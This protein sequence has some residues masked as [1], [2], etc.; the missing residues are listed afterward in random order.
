MLIQSE[1][2]ALLNEILNQT[3]RLRK[4][5][6]QAVY[7]CP[8]CKHYKRKLEINLDT[9]QWHCWT[10]NIKGSFLGSFLG[11]V[12]ANQAYRDQMAK[13]TGDL[14][15]AQR[16]KPVSAFN[17]VVLPDEFHPLSKP[18]S[19]VEYKNALYY[20]KR[21]GL[22]MEDIIRHNIGYCESGTYEYHIIV[23]SY[24]ADCKLNFF[25]GRRYYDTEGTIAYKKPECSMN[26]VGFESFVNY[27]EEI[28]LCEGVFDAIAIRNNAV[29][30]FGKYPSKL[31]R[32]RMILNNVKRANIILDDDAVKDAIRNYELLTKDVPGLEVS[33][34][35]LNGK[36]P[37]DIGFQLTHEFIR[38]AIP[39]GE[40]DLLK[41]ELYG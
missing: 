37:S 8:E 7:F 38:N 2:V 39:F 26:I 35:R 15:I 14:R 9:G 13:L 31:L 27:E 40:E 23:P 34:I 22:L 12:K 29:P 3:A 6:S 16:N 1:I 24:D 21:R 41:Y 11:K 4:G 32:E 33:V 36:D 28:N 10:C 5:G 25:I 18:I 20:L 17:E 19:S 30:L